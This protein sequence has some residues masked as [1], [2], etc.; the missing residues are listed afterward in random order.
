MDRRLSGSLFRW[1]FQV[2]RCRIPPRRPGQE[3]VDEE[4]GLVSILYG[5][6][7]PGSQLRQHVCHDL[8]MQPSHL[9]LEPHF[10]G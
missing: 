7:K 10:R 4:M 5:R 2:R 8:Q 9:G 3:H 1:C 6:F